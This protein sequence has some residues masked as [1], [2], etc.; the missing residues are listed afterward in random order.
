VTGAA[1]WDAPWRWGYWTYDN[2]YS[3]EVIVIDDTT[4]IDYSQPIVLTPAPEAGVDASTTDGETQSELD[5]SRA[6]FARG[7]YDTAMTMINRAIAKRPNDTLL[8]EF[9]GL[10][11]FA[12]RQYS[13]AAAAIYAVLSI[14]PGWDWATLGDFYPDAETYTAQLRA[15][16]QQRDANLNAPDV[17]FL[18]AYHYLCCGYPEAAAAEF[19]E[20]VRLSPKDQLSAQLLAGLSSGSKSETTAAPA[21]AGEEPAAPT[22]VA[23]KPVAAADL[24]GVWTATR[25]DGASFSLSLTGDGTYSWQYAQA[26]K[27]QEFSGVFTVADNL[28]IL[29]QNNAPAMIGQV[30]LVDDQRFNFKLIGSGESDP[31]LTFFRK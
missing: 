28:L 15:L 19:K 17:R 8:H 11:L 12:T 13:Q 3:T 22:T 6:A 27:S 26:G 24:Q 30:T 7:D 1:V 29:K 20:V 31:G 9:R 23:S 18:L 10:S 4:S 2:P 16:E 21:P 25:T 14:A 5:A